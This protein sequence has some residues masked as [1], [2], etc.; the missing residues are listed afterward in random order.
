MIPV[1]LQAASSHRR[2]R[3]LRYGRVSPGCSEAVTEVFAARRKVSFALVPESAEPPR[4]AVGA[5]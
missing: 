2:R 5:S 3:A 4:A 1:S